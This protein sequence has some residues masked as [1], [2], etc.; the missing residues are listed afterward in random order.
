M[1]LSIWPSESLAEYAKKGV[2]CTLHCMMANIAFMCGGY[3]WG[4]TNP[5]ANN[6]SI[7]FHVFCCS[8]V[9]VWCGCFRQPISVDRCMQTSRILWNFS[10]HNS[11]RL[12]DNNGLPIAHN[13]AWHNMHTINMSTA[14]SCTHVLC[15]Y[16]PVVIVGVVCIC[17]DRV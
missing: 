17:S 10:P 3:Q 9:C 12:H 15:F 13:N 16:F 7:S 8:Y 11:S 4:D 1:S 6:I 2:Q 14:F 5:R